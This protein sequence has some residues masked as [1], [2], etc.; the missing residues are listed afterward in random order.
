MKTFIQFFLLFILFTT[1]VSCSN[2]QF[3]EEDWKANKNR[4]K[5]VN[6]LIRSNR[7]IGK[8][9]EEVINILGQNEILPVQ[10]DTIP[11]KFSVEY[12]TG[13]RRWIDFERLR[14]Y[15]ERGMVVRT[16]KNYD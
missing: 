14:I 16:E 4:V 12:L 2:R 11:G 15:F 5:Q 10:N 1:V 6:S 9:Y 8:S 13:G 3:N 7:L